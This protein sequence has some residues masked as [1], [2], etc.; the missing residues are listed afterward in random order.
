MAK[1]RF[2]ESLAHKIPASSPGPLRVAPPIMVAPAAVWPVLGPVPRQSW[3]LGEVAELPFHPPDPR[4]MEGVAALPD[5]KKASDIKRETIVHPPL[6]VH[7][8]LHRGCKLILA[9]GSKSYKSWSLIDLGLAICTGGDWWGMK[10]ERA[11]VVYINFELIDGFFSTRLCDV[12][13]KRG[14]A[15]P[16][17]FH[18][19]SLRSIC[20][21][22]EILAKVLK[23][24]LSALPEHERPGLIVVDP[25]YKALGDLDENS[26]SDMTKLMFLVEGLSDSIGA[27]VAF[28]THFAKGNQA[29]KEAMDRPSGSG[30]FA[31]DPDSIM[32]MTR[33]EE[34]GCYVV[35]SELRYL[36]PLSKFVVRWDFPAMVVDESK[37]PELIYQGKVVKKA[38]GEEKPAAYSTEDVLSCLSVGG[39]VAEAWKKAV[40]TRFGK[41]SKD[42]YAHKA[43]LLRE[44]TVI[45]QGPRYMPANVK[46]RWQIEGSDEEHN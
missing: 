15:L 26:A 32:V 20:Y 8:L 45:K 9:G 46:L 10:T 35:E 21:D 1:S 36:A 18:V 24:R 22:L 38:E 41:A 34:P 13:E 3:S 44:G 2:R 42:F 19:W 27:A 11:G 43:K 40:I 6:L 17:N 33:H 28:G 5:F 37:D 25:V 4:I 14:I 16:D 30:V 39:L 29:T 12:A 31:R 23:A 7:G